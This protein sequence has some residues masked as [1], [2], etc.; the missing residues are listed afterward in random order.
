MDIDLITN[1][2]FATVRTGTPLILIAL[3]EMVCE[4]SGVLNLGQEGMVLMGAVL[5]FIAA[6]VTGHAGLGVIAAIFAGMLMSALFGFLAISLVSNQVATG[7]ALT[8][9]GIG[10]SAFLGSSYVGMGLEG[11][12]AWNIPLLS[13]IPVIGKILFSHDPLVY[14]SW[15]IFA[16]LFWVFKSSRIGLTIRAVGENPEAANATGISVMKVR[17]GAVLFGGA[18]AGLAGG[19]LSLAYTPMWSEGM[20]A[21]RG[22]IALALVVF[23]SWKA[24]RILLGAYL[25]GAASIMH[26]VLQG[27]GFEASPNLLAMLPYAATIIVLVVLANDAVKAKLSTPLALGQPYRPQV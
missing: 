25:F 20:S 26:L 19:Y 18:M 10:L 13:D 4:K 16:V 21:G 22:W 17:Y 7:L 8:I 27:L 11:I 14:L 9:F 12:A 15:I 5:G 3:G 24:E 2:L 6:V 1:I 23:A